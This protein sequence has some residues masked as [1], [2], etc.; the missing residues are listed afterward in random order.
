MLRNFALLTFAAGM[1]SRVAAIISTQAAQ[2]AAQL[3]AVVVR[4]S[5]MQQVEAFL[6]DLKA[7]RNNRFDGAGWG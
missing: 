7:G 5:A 3:L 6:L 1:R 2:R 4:P